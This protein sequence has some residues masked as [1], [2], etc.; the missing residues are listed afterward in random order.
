ME[1]SS[2]VHLQQYEYLYSAIS[3]IGTLFVLTSSASRASQ[4]G[5][6]TVAG[7]RKA[8]LSCGSGE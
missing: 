1:L 4:A 2:K 5:A 3:T 8:V 7:S 6:R